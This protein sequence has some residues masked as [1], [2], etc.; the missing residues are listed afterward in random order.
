MISYISVNDPWKPISSNAAREVENIDPFSPQAQSQLVEFDVLRTQIETK[1]P[2]NNK[3]L[4]TNSSTGNNDG[5][6]QESCNIP[7]LHGITMKQEPVSTIQVSSGR[8]E[9]TKVLKDMKSIVARV[10]TLVYIGLRYNASTR[11]RYI[12]IYIHQI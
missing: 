9:S 3:A 5:N 12:H 10:A 1:E 6:F 8:Q 7:W 11:F 2:A 4:H